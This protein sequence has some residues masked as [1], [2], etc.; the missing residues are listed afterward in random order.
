MVGDALVRD[1]RGIITG[2]Y[3]PFVLASAYQ[4]IVCLRGTGLEVVAHEGLIRATRCGA[5]VSPDQLFAETDPEDRLFIDGMCQALH[6]RN[7]S[8]AMPNGL[9][10]FININPAIYHCTDIIDR[11]YDHLLAAVPKH[12]LTPD[13]LVCEILE[14]D[15][16]SATVLDRLVE[17]LRRCGFAIA[18]DD[19]GRR[20]SNFARYVALRPDIVKI[21]RDFFIDSTACP[22]QFALLSR[23]VETMQ[24]QQTEILVEGIE[25]HAM[26]DAAI[27]V[28]ATRFQGFGISRP[29][30]LPANFSGINAMQRYGSPL[31]H[32]TSAP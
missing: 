16:L 32:V 5:T 25:S 24:A 28:G 15:A 11:E 31:L 27:K 20:S 6:I 1:E 7:Y 29:R 19:F 21:D 2:A 18:L 17:K 10:L 14:T 30:N 26:L 8:H 12:G 3:G 22:Q 13:R 9:P 23:A 4:P